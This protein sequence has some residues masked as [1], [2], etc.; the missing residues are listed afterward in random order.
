MHTSTRVAALA[1]LTVA[2]SVL[3]QNS[4]VAWW[5]FNEAGG[6]SALDSGTL[7]VDGVLQGA[8]GFTAG[9]SG[10]AISIPG[11]IGDF[12]NMGN[13]L[14]MVGTSF[15]MQAW[16]RTTNATSANTIAVGKHNAGTF[17]GYM[18]RLNYDGQYGLA[19]RAQFYQSNSPANTAVG[20]SVV[21]DGVWH[22][23]LATYTLGGQLRLYVDGN[24]ERTIAAQSIISNSVAFLVG[25]YTVSGVQRNGFQGELDEVQL[26]DYALTADQVTYLA[27]HPGAAIPAPASG[28]A[29][30][31]LVAI[32]RR[33][34]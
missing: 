10:N 21:T 13:V 8:C 27:D 4:P 11:G 3:A 19:Q 20:T 26:Y 28:V 9:V 5:K 23:L 16:M 2:T 7:G 34:R 12:V 14:P 15:S 32:G 1:T 29:L 24:L 6:V 31:G 25:G 33:R 22:H 18:M 30:L 17:N